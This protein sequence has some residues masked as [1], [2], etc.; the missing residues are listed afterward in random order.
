MAEIARHSGG[1]LRPL[2]RPSISWR[3][4]SKKDSRTGQRAKADEYSRPMHHYMETGFTP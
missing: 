3:R 1:A 4:N 2:P